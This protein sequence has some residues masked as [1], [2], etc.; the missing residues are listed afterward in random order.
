MK[1]PAPHPISLLDFVLYF[2][3]WMS[4]HFESRKYHLVEY[5]LIYSFIFGINSM[6]C[7]L[8]SLS[9]VMTDIVVCVNL[10]FNV[11]KF[12][13]VVVIFVLILF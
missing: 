13:S 3:A 10:I 5:S 7:S 8:F 1:N 6:N 9:I 12:G 4:Q 2:P 11:M